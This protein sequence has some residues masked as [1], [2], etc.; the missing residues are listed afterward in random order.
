ML[1]QR[2]GNEPAK[3][4]GLGKGKTKKIHG[5]LW[6]AVNLTL[7]VVLSLS[8]NIAFSISPCFL[9][10]VVSKNTFPS[11][12]CPFLSRRCVQIEKTYL[13][14]RKYL[15]SDRNLP[16]T[17]VLEYQL[18]QYFLSNRYHAVGIF[19]WHGLSREY[20][21]WLHVSLGRGSSWD[22]WSTGRNARRYRTASKVRHDNYNACFEEDGRINGCGVLSR[23]QNAQWK[24]WVAE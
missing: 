12:N 16:H 22:F 11:T 17:L 15:P 19:P 24:Y 10:K 9:W 2:A 18:N 4:Q 23:K 6:T 5:I 21:G 3:T 7:S 14:V 8:K 13:Y 1:L 20:D